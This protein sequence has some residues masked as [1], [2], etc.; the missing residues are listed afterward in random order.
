MRVHARFWWSCAAALGTVLAL[1]AGSPPP[2]PVP[3]AD[4]TPGVVDNAG[5]EQGLTGWT[6]TGT[7]AA[8]ESGG[9]D[10]S[11]LTHWSASRYRVSTSQRVE[12]LADG[13][14]TVSAW[15]K[16]GGL[17]ATSLRL[18]GCGVDD[19]TTLP[20]TLQDDAWV[21]LSVS[22]YVVGGACTI[23]VDT[24]G[25]ANAWASV[26]DVSLAP[27]QVTRAI[28]GGDL[29]GLAKNEDAGATY[30]SATGAPGDPVRLLADAG[31]NLGRLKVWVD[32]AD[33]YNE[34]THVV[35]TAKR[36]KAAGMALMVD[37]HYSD[38][39]TDPGAQ[40]V[41]AAWA[42][43][44][45]AQ[46]AVDVHD[47]TVE[48]LTALK[49]A[50]ITADYVQVGNEINPGMLWPWGQTWDV[51]PSD[52]VPGAQW[53]N[54]AAF[55]TAGHDA[56]KEVSPTTRT[57]LH[58]TN[59]NNGI[60]SLTWWFDEVTARGVPFDVIGLSYY[61]YWHGSLADLQE[62]VT[63]LSDRYDRDVVVVETA[64]PFTLD[65]DT[66]A[67]E[68]ILN[69]PDELVAGYP[70]TPAGQAS[71]L[72]AVQDV[73]AS[74][75]GGR[76]LGTVYWEPAWT[77]VAGNGWD[78]A[79][80]TSG[81]AWENQAMF[82][83]DG[84]LLPVAAELQADPVAPAARAASTT[85]LRVARGR[86]Q[87]AAATV[88]HVSVRAGR[89]APTGLVVVRDGGVEVGRALLRAR[90]RGAV[91]VRLGPLPRGTHVLTAQYAGDLS[92][93]GSTSRPLTVR[94]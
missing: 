62:A 52:D 38:R 19:A 65:D 94:R 7:G 31:M 61:G 28:R 12:G 87:H 66:P 55:L 54:L 77:S 89:T 26:D 53:D 39:W 81:N 33:G 80:P 75:P 46:L 56:V 36:I 70:A 2:A 20:G 11:R 85:S 47:H 43:H 91:D 10:G 67:W 42:T 18:T 5:F 57:I 37:F 9:R 21:R 22:A 17:D 72:R 68:N 64:Y 29:S 59:I 93:L 44:D 73:V 24:D 3:A 86:G 35:A 13:W 23:S 74:A 6:V 63:T 15:V 82:G 71:A 51:D 32:P 8:V 88:A 79:D 16:S 92:V 1:T 4:P 78:P 27:G 41:P 30:A 58:L 14:W 48:V 25:P 34:V 50:G 69:T 60:G 84:R 45:A 76:G 40:G 90:D 83:F 49:S